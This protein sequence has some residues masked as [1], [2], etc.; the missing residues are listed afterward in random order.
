MNFKYSAIGVRSLADGLAAQPYAAQVLDAVA[1]ATRAALDNP[2]LT[3]WHDGSVVIDFA[4]TI[5]RLQGAEACELVHFQAVRHSL[6]PFITPFL[7]V[8]LAMGGGSPG[9]IYAQ[10]NDTLGTVMSGP[11]IAWEEK[12]TRSGQLTI[13]HPDD[14]A[15]ISWLSWRGSL[16][17]VYFLANVAGELTP[18]HDLAGPRSLVFDCSWR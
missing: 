15:K 16:R 10:M 5:E 12:T 11:R 3:R 14:L 18:R 2:R 6:G 17:F 8:S 13:F 9:F 1:P 4:E 7:R